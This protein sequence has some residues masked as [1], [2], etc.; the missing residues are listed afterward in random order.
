MLLEQ[1]AHQLVGQAKRSGTKIRPK[2]VR[3]GIF[4]RFPNFDKYL[5]EVAGDVICGMAVDY[6]G[7]DVMHHLLNLI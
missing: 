3:S 2:V 4:A 1:E 6:V 7:M 5:S